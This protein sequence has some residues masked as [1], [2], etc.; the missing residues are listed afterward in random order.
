MIND[1]NF[2][3]RMLFKNPAFTVVAVLS[4]ALGIGANTAIFQLLNAVRLKSLPI[5]NAQELA[6]VRLREHD[7]DLTRGNK[8]IMRYGPITNPLW[9]KVR[10]GQQGFSSIAAWAHGRFNLAQ[11]GEVRIARGLWVSGNFFNV[12]GVNPV[13]GRTFNEADDQR[14]AAAWA[15]ACRSPRS[16]RC[17]R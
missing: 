14:R 1:L 5:R 17:R 6:Q 15:C 7:A 13:L 16:A 8:E 3:I 9:E 10:D 4:L 11:G 12:L 2:G